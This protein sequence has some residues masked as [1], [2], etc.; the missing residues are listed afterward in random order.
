[1][2]QCIDFDAKGG[3]GFFGAMGFGVATAA[4]NAR[5]C[6]AEST[7]E[8][9]QEAEVMRSTTISRR[10]VSNVGHC[11]ASSKTFVQ[12][13]KMNSNWVVIDRNLQK[14]VPVWSALQKDRQDVVN[15]L[16]DA[17]S[18]NES[19]A[20]RRIHKFKEVAAKIWHVRVLNAPKLCRKMGPPPEVADLC[21]RVYSSAYLDMSLEDLPKL[22]EGLS[23]LAAI[24]QDRR[25]EC[26]AMDFCNNH[27]QQGECTWQPIVGLN[28]DH[29]LMCKC[30]KH[31]KGEKCE[32]LI[33]EKECTCT[34]WNTCTSHPISWFQDDCNVHGPDYECVDW[35]YCGFIHGVGA[36]YKCQK[37]YMC[38]PDYEDHDCCSCD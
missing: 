32:E 36:K 34:K 21:D 2:S 8:R 14:C 5:A 24:E 20:L 38:R 26:A 16:L 3:A 7:G 22:W 15:L 27:K 12:S 30:Q 23:S 4:G 31:Y 11:P 28:E 25:K 19:I 10:C 13:M 18:A 6:S 17:G 9:K 33:A 37:K 29:V 1:M 35:E